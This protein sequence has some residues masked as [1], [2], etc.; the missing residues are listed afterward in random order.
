MAIFQFF[1]KKNVPSEGIAAL[2]QMRKTTPQPFGVLGNYVPLRKNEGDLYRAIREAVPLVDACIYK[3]IRLCGG[4]SAVC[5]DE[6][7]ERG[8][9]EF[10]ERVNVGR[11]Q[12]GINAFL[13]QYLD[14]MLVFGQGVGEIVLD[15]GEREIAALLCGRVEDVEIR[16]GDNPLDFAL[17]AMDEWGQ[18]KALPHQELLLFTPFN[19]EAH[20]PYGVSLLRSMPFL[21]ELLSKIYHAI[22][23]NWERMGNVRFAVVY[24]PQA[25]EL[26][27]G[28]AQERSQQLAR[29]WSR[30]MEESRSGGVRDFVAVGDVDIK[31][32]GADNQVLDSSVPIRQIM[33]Q[34][35]SKTGIP[36]FMLGLSWSSTERMSAQQSDLLTTE[37]TAIRRALTPAIEKICRTWLRLHGYGCGFQVVWD[38]INLQD[39]LE[40]AKADWYREQTRKLALE[41]DR[42][43]TE[44]GLNE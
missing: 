31:V 17:C 19:P 12:Y 40:E 6:K 11:G 30:A 9:R 44:S 8:L 21:A 29:E 3:I 7:A 42:L 18:V 10:L 26:E 16:E 35:V 37:M 32:I 13:D 25:G 1:K 15:C 20:S 22:G 5:D 2:P 36:P 43:A 41:N 27:R 4:V 38:D 28:M 33:E 24:K 34:L 23:V 39:L 14:S